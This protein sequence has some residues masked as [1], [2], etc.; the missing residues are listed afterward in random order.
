MA[1]PKRSRDASQPSLADVAEIAGVSAQT[2]SRVINARGTVLPAT[3]AR[4]EEALQQSG[5]RA[6]V[7]ARALAT[8]RFGTL[9]VITFDLAAVGNLRVVDAVI[10]TGQA[11]GYSVI[12]ATVSSRTQAE[13]RSALH[14][15]TNRAIDALIIVEAKIIN[16]LELPLPTDIPVIIAEGDD[17]GDFVAVGV[18]QTVGARQLVQHI[19]S[20]GHATVHHICGPSDSYPAIRRQAAWETVLNEH[21]CAVPEPVAGDWTVGS[22]HRAAL[23]L[24]DRTDVTAIFAGNDHMAIG[25]IRA[26][27]DLGR[28]VP[29]DVSIAGFDDIGVSAYL[30][31]PLTTVRQDLDR[32]GRLCVERAL[33]ELQGST[34][35]PTAPIQLLPPELIVRA[36][37]ASPPT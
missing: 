31:P 18:D 32:V 33:A 29:E 36:S 19:L 6:N 20:L 27:A 1:R 35:Q 7:A 5:Y 2:V 25:A 37:T 28:R 24:L 17:H 26:A 3:R 9:G 13:L 23:R 34:E 12:V 15:L 14:S 22:G 11:A 10:D 16:T 8:G 4:V 30:V 21:G